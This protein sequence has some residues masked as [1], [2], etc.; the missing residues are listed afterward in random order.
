MSDMPEISPARISAFL[1]DCNLLATQAN[2]DAVTRRL[3][4]IDERDGTRD[5]DLELNVTEYTASVLIGALNEFIDTYT[6]TGYEGDAKNAAD[7]RSDIMIQF[8]EDWIQ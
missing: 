6:G 7:L 5:I 8:P 3:E 4:E 2:I 1:I